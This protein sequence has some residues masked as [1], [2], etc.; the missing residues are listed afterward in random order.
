MTPTD[1]YWILELTFDALAACV[2]IV[3][4]ADPESGTKH[5]EIVVNGIA[6][7]RSERYHEADSLCLGDYS[8]ITI[9]RRRRH[10]RYTLDTGDATVTFESLQKVEL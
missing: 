8:G 10:W 7:F 9:S 3:L 2:Q 5:R 1:R 4:T 6:S